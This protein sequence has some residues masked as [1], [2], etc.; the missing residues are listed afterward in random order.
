MRTQERKQLNNQMMEVILR[1]LYYC[2]ISN[3]SLERAI[4]LFLS[5]NPHSELCKGKHHLLEYVTSSKSPQPAQ[6][7]RAQGLILESSSNEDSDDEVDHSSFVRPGEDL[8]AESSSSS[9]AE[10]DNEVED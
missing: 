4:E 1:I 2:S 10:D 7:K 8:V 3:V 9:F 6:G 5:E